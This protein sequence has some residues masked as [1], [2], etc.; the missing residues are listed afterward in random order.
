MKQTFIYTLL[1]IL[2]SMTGCKKDEIG[3]TSVCENPTYLNSNNH[4]KN[5]TYKSIIKKYTEKGLPGISL[6]IND[7]HGTW[8]GAS[9]RA[10]IGSSIDMKPCHISKVASITKLFIGTLVLKLVEEEV[11]NLDDKISNHLP[12]DVVSNVKNVDKCTLRNLLNHTSGIADVIKVKSFYMGVLNDPSKFWT[13][14]EL[15]KFVYNDDAVFETGKDVGYSNTNLLLAIMIIE[16]VTGKDHADLLREKIID[17]LELTDTYYH[18]HESLPD[19]VAQGY[20][21]LHNNGTLLNMSN[22]N[23][24]SGNGYGG[25]FST[26]F[27]LQTYSDALFRHRTL[28]SDAS[29]DELMTFTEMEEEKNRAFGITV[30]KDFMDRPNYQYAYGHRGRD[31]A[32]SADMFWFPNKDVT[33]IYLINYGT[34]AKSSLQQVFFDFREE[35]VNELMKN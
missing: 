25:V 26:V 30:M 35:L 34:D 31:L 1:I 21:D 9:G 28:L 27:D 22:Y 23:T 16:E 19:F 33:M 24:G 13:P 12:S 29:Y 7:E 2:I 4:P 11:I 10:D 32:Y 18:W 14:D 20:F 15:I 8:A 6:L 17:P 3:E 5:N